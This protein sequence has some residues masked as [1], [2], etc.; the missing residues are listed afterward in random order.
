MFKFPWTRR[1]DVE[2]GKRIEAQARL[3]QIRRDTPRMSAH[4]EAVHREIVLNDW[5]RT[6]KAI[7]GGKDY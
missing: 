6:A 2:R 1:A 5:T 7:F 3:A 4:R